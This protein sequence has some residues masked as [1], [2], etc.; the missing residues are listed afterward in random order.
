MNE[1]VKCFDCGKVVEATEEGL[2]PGGR[3]VKMSVSVCIVPKLNPFGYT[4]D[5]SHYQSIDGFLCT[6]CADRA[7]DA[8][9]ARAKVWEAA[10]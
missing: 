5:S 1:P 8:V 7:R 9:A 6:E 3:R 10:R 2:Y 4:S